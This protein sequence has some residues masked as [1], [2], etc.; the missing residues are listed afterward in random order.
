MVVR[1]GAPFDVMQSMLQRSATVHAYLTGWSGQWTA[2]AN[3]RQLRAIDWTVLATPTRYLGE[4]ASTLELCALPPQ[5]ESLRLSLMCPLGDV[6]L[7]SLCASLRGA[8]NLTS[9]WLDACPVVDFLVITNGLAA[10]QLRDVYAVPLRELH[11]NLTN[12]CPSCTYPTVVAI[13]GLLWLTSL[14]VQCAQ[15]MTSP[16]LVNDVRRIVDQLLAS[17][18]PQLG[19]TRFQYDGFPLENRGAFTIMLAA[20]VGTMQQL[21]VP[22]FVATTV[23]EEPT[24][25]ETCVDRMQELETLHV[26]EPSVRL[27]FLL[28]NK[29]RLSALVHNGTVWDSS[30]LV[31]QLA[32]LKAMEQFHL[33]VRLDPA[34]MVHIQTV[35][36]WPRC[37]YFYA[38]GSVVMGAIKS[39]AIS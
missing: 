23:Y 5:L 13:D 20:S 6:V 2:M 1:A 30:K 31:A 4:P 25:I 39:Y 18:S 33:S 21:A 8:N 32:A 14:S 9:L 24:V 7:T 38:G 17:R 26:L 15:L 29:P 3:A 12:S 11:L 22:A 37:V 27:D 34:T 35:V 36:R 16:A 19:M 10:R 28:A